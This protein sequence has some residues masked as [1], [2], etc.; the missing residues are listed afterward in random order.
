MGISH[1]FY[2]RDRGLGGLGLGEPRLLGLVA[3]LGR[4]LCLLCFLRLLR[5]LLVLL[6]LLLLV[7]S[8]GL[9]VF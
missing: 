5:I 7:P 3:A 6:V 1:V 4:S 8:L 9:L 2:L